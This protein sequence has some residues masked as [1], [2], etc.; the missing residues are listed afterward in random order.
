V[1]YDRRAVVLAAFLVGL[2]LGL[3]GLVFAIVRGAALW[4]QAKRTG[5]ILTQ[6]LASLEERSARSER[7]LAEWERSNAELNAALG[8]L[9]LSRAR[10]QVLQDALAKSQARVGWL[11]IFLPG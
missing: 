8:R 9:R 1:G 10:L 2:A 3:A 7:H 5:G 11:R 6:E 4:R